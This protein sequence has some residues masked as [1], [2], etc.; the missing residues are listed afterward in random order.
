MAEPKIAKLGKY[1]IVEE[2]GRGAMGVVYKGFDPH[3]ER[4]VAVKTIRQ[5]LFDDGEGAMHMARFKREAQAAGRLVHPGVVGVYDYGEEGGV[6]Y[7]AM[8]FVEGRTLK[9]F[10]DK[11][12]RFELKA[13]VD[14]MTQV[15]MALDYSHNRGVIHRDI[16]PANVVITSDGTAKIMDFGVARIES[17]TMTQAGTMIGTPSYMSPEQFM[18]QTV[19]NRSDIYSAGVVLYQMLTGEKPFTGSLTSIMHKVMKTIPEP[20][21]ALNLRVT[22]A[23]DAVVAKA[24]A[25]RPDDRYET[26]KAFAEALG[27]AARGD[28]EPL[29]TPTAVPYD[30]DATIAG[31]DVDFSPASADDATI[32][33]GGGSGPSPTPP[34]IDDLTVAAAGPTGVG[35][36]LDDEATVAAGGATPVPDD[37]ATVAAGGGVAP[38]PRSDEPD[39]SMTQT[40]KTVLAAKPEPSPSAT[41]APTISPTSAP[42]RDRDEGA[43]KRSPV[44][45]IAAGVVFFLLAGVGAWMFLGGKPDTPEPMVTTQVREP[46]PAEKPP[47]VEPS[48][49]PKPVSEP[50]VEVKPPV[51]EPPPQE[52][53]ATAV[54]PDSVPDP[55]LDPV[56]PIA[57]EPSSEPVSDPS[58][59]PEPVSVPVSESTTLAALPPDIEKLPPPPPPPAFSLTTTAGDAPVFKV[60]ERMVLELKANRDVYVYCFYE[61]YDGNVLRIFPNRFHTDAL[62]KAATVERVPGG[63]MG[64]DFSWEKGGGLEEHIYCFACESRVEDRLPESLA[65]RDLQPL[66]LPDGPR[67][68]RA[69][70]QSVDPKVVE[71]VLTL[72]VE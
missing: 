32:A 65:T 17:S 8:E 54:L 9:S 21:S 29:D 23:F 1:D 67:S 68:L 16:K 30:D 71:H 35:P 50:R 33:A 56:T 49:V 22:G 55:V 6:A 26:A 13:T 3:I 69:V 5:E 14:I 10:F 51:S 31:G 72:R 12:E 25:K 61:L 15:L 60:G 20:P 36:M 52:L 70:F 41:P 42:A 47:V 27:R 38:P 40:A 34:V 24:M 48:E 46:A 18:G 7:I 2:L 37:E 43:K 4:W 11:D 45:A 59:V 62:V 58:P 66:F 63:S 44:L 39:A 64:F 57:A 28:A 53:P 19:D